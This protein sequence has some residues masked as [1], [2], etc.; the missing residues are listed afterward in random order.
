[1]LRTAARMRL[2]AASSLPAVSKTIQ[3]TASVMGDSDKSVNTRVFRL[4]VNF[5]VF[6]AYFLT[7]ARFV[8]VGGPLWLRQTTAHSTLRSFLRKPD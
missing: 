8:D 2:K 5:S 4:T 7:G 1:M 6:T 3:K